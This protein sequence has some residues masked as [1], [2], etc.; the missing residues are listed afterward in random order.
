MSLPKTIK[1]VVDATY[2]HMPL[3]LANGTFGNGVADGGDYVAA[4]MVEKIVRSILDIAG[5]RIDT[6]GQ[7]LIY[8]STVGTKTPRYQVEEQRNPRW[9]GRR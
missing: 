4:W 3:K 6:D 9:K 2:D 1:D 5:I 7:T 8:P